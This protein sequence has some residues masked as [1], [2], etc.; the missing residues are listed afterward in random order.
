[1]SDAL[2]DTHVNQ[3]G[4]HTYVANNA[5]ATSRDAAKA[6]LPRSGTQRRR[7]FD[8]LCAFPDGLTDAQIQ[9]ALDMNPSSERPRRLELVEAGLVRDS[10]RRRNGMAVWTAVEGTAAT[11]D[12]KDDRDDPLAS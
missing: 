12:T 1:M 4:G 8:A 5:P 6:I 3:W 7:V 9:A 11:A 10:G 2:F